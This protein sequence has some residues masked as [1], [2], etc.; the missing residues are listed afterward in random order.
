V[1]AVLAQSPV[2]RPMRMSEVKAIAAIERTVYSHPWTAGNFRDSL[3]AG[4]SCWVL[5]CAGEIVAYGVLMIGVDEAHLL[6]LSV[7]KEWQ[8]HGLGRQLLQDF[9][10]IARRCDVQRIFLEVRPSNTAAR[11]LYR[12]TGFHE[13]AVRRSYYPAAVGREDAILM[14]RRLG[15]EQG[16]EGNR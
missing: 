11:A 6:N 10:E 16:E 8:R 5:E 1:S 7:A 12:Q 13:H 15:G 14:M 4:Y 3:Q 9:I 2:L